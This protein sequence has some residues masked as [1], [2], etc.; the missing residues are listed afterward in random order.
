MLNL[1]FQACHNVT[2]LVEILDPEDKKER[3]SIFDLLVSNILELVYL[4]VVVI[5]V[6]VII[7]IIVIVVIIIS[8]SSIVGSSSLHQKVKLLCHV[9][10]CDLSFVVK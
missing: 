3:V 4:V 1:P 9:I 2:Q 6:N 7:T 8:H 10:R 5:I